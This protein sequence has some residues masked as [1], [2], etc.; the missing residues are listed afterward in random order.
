[1]DNAFEWYETNHAE[2]ES[3]YPYAGVTHSSCKHTASTGFETT[4]Y[5]DVTL[6]SEEALMEAL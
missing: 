1:M 2:S 5:H 6:N 3:A 4:A